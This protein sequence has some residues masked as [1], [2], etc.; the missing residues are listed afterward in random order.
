MEQTFQSG[1]QVSDFF[2]KHGKWKFEKDVVQEILINCTENIELFP[3]LT[4][5]HST[6]WSPI[7]LAALLDD[8]VS[9]KKLIDMDNR[10]MD[11]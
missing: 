2:L 1:K 11:S 5:L 7:H 8:A 9:L 10:C 4:K 3:T 6:S